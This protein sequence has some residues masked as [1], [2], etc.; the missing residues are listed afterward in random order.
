MNLPELFQ[1]QASPSFKKGQD[2][3]WNAVFSLAVILSIPIIITEEMTGFES[4]IKSW[5]LGGSIFCL[6]TPLFFPKA[7]KL[8]IYLFYLSLTRVYDFFVV[9]EGKEIFELVRYTGP[10]MPIFLTY[11]LFPTKYAFLI[12]LVNSIVFVSLRYG[13]LALGILENPYPDIYNGPTF[14]IY[15]CVLLIVIAL[16][17]IMRHFIIESE[18]EYVLINK[19]YYN[20][21]SSILHDFNAHLQSLGLYIFKANHEL[22]EPKEMVKLE[23]CFNDLTNFSKE[24]SKLLRDP[25][26]LYEDLQTISIDDVISRIK[27]LFE[28]RLKNKD[29]SLKI[30]EKDKFP[31]ITNSAI[32]IN[33]ILSNILSNSIKFNPKDSR[34]TLTFKMSSLGPC[35]QIEDEAGGLSPEL[36]NE[37]SK[38]QNHRFTTLGTAGEKGHGFGLR[39]VQYYSKVLN[40]HFEATP[41]NKG[42]TFSFYLEGNKS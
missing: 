32:F 38:N 10:I 37:L 34:I 31:I 33:T 29:I 22:N 2:F 41:T 17:H 25:N 6:V 42:T 8:Y 1:I 39:I 40:I 3:I 18:R 35:V 4:G 7:N 26:R 23:E 14:L 28:D 15:F 36:L 19:N 13:V 16:F 5:V 24:M 21:N 11:T 27:I 30:V 12:S 9:P 20:L